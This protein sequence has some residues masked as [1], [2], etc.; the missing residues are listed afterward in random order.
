[1]DGIDKKRLH[2]LFLAGKALSEIAD[3]LGSTTGSIRTT[4][5]H[6]R[7]RDPLAWPRRV[8]YPGM[9]DE[10]PLM[11]H[12]YE[13]TDCVVTF[14][15]EDYEEVDHSQTACPICHSDEGVED[16]GYGQFILTKL[17][18]DAAS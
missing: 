17:P 2:Q 13:C 7:L 10:P 14:T 11:M 12:L 18:E 15:V 3:E 16:K 4:I 6:E 1:M 8:R 9:P 5:Y